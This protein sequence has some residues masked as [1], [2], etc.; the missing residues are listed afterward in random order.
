MKTLVLK[1][2]A[3]YQEN[4]VISSGFIKIQNGKI[5]DVGEFYMAQ[6]NEEVMV[7]PPS[8]SIIPGM[9]DLHIHG[10]GGA[11]AMDG[12]KE[13]LDTISAVLPKEG[14]TSYLATTM[15]QPDEAIEEALKNAAQYIAEEI[16]PTGKAEV[17]GIHLE[18]PFI[19]ATV[20]GAQPLSFIQKPNIEKFKRWQ[21]LAK[22]HIK[23]VTLAPEEDK[24]YELTMHLKNTGVVPS[25]GHSNAT[26]EGVKEAIAHGV[27]HATHL[28][29]GMRNAHH[30]EPGVAG[31][32]LLHDEVLVEIIA[33][34]IHV[35]PDMVQL[36]YKLKGKEGLVLITDAMRAKCMQ[37][38]T[39]DLGG[40]TVTV[41]DKRAVLA[42]GT[43]AGSIL[44]MYDAARNM[45][46]CTGCTLTDVIQMGSI[47][48][49]RQL[50]VFNRK[51]SIE[52]GKD[53]DL[54]VLNENLE[55]AMTF[56]RGHLAF[57]KS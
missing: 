57:E 38:G 40:Q 21:N 51:G 45:M 26:G 5:V 8:Y 41:D 6:S 37:S 46:E 56:C 35:H 28:F 10:A 20:A 9:I 16:N 27:C 47:N 25:I 50:G 15:T 42:D 34:G 53:A 3:V 33:D 11:D 2:A 7:L 22:G 23:L 4:R 17:L 24:G 49:A 44:K 39:Y 32:V 31:T 29:N 55:I 36:A 48:P 43:L 30:R 52:A 14:T 19:N 54:V 1:N 13:A 18:G 12:T